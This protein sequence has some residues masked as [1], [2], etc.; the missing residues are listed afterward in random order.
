MEWKTIKGAQPMTP[1]QL[2]G[3]PL[4]SGRHTTLT[5]DK[6]DTLPGATATGTSV[7]KTSLSGL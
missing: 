7:K 6:A 1:L 4:S 2:N 3:I 5:S